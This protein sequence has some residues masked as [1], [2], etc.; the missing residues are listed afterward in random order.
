MCQQSWLCR[1]EF[2]NCLKLFFCLQTGQSAAVFY[3]PALV[4]L[5]F[6]PDF[7]KKH[8]S[9]LGTSLSLSHPHTPTHSQTISSPKH[10]CTCK[11]K[12]VS[13]RH[14]HIHQHTHCHWDYIQRTHT[15]CPFSFMSSLALSLSLIRDGPGPEMGPSASPE[16]RVEVD[17]DEDARAK[18]T[19]LWSRERGNILR[20]NEPT[21]IIIVSTLIIVLSLFF[22][23]PLL[24]SSSLLLSFQFR[25]SGG[26]TKDKRFLTFPSTRLHGSLHWARYPFSSSKSL[27]QDPNG[28]CS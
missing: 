16:M 14:P 1:S 26:Q 27:I 10:I 28:I 20:L 17:E 11:L 12:I 8:F 13:H 4:V 23:L 6:I 25:A 2:Q 7:K 19:S 24:P 21:Q 3:S 15:H 18:S 22:L 9:F 5:S